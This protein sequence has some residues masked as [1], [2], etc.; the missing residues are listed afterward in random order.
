MDEKLYVIDNMD[1]LSDRDMIKKTEKTHN[2]ITYYYNENY[3]S[4]KTVQYELIDG[5][6]IVYHDLILNHDELFPIEKT[7]FIRMNYCI[8]GRCELDYKNKEVFYMGKDDLVVAFLDKGNYRHR[9]P[10]NKY[11]GIS[12]TITEEKLNNL[13]KKIFIDTK[14]TSTMLIEKIKEYNMYMILSNNS[15]VRDIM[16]ELILFDDE[17]WRE[18]AIIKFTELILLLI[19]IDVQASEVKTKYFNRH[20][21]DKVKLIKKEVIQNLDTYITIEQIS[22]KYNIPS[23]TFE[24][25]FK[26]IYGKTYYSFIKEFRIK[27]AAEKLCTTKNTIAEIAIMVGYKNPSK[28]S[29]A[30]FDNIGL[31]PREFRKN[32]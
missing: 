26:A 25:C 31:T 15:R 28:F 29:K 3:I 9:F 16:E 22:K 7:G 18:R 12:I 13:L 30:F 5:I 2:K 24:Q 32:R 1:K 14:I 11:K 4:G 20:L 21:T 23:K 27:V 19:N 8:S 6:W 17:F 10:L